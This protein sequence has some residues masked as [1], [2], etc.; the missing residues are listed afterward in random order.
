MKKKT[1]KFNRDLLKN[2]NFRNKSISST[3][4]YLKDSKIENIEYDWNK[5]SLIIKEAVERSISRVQDGIK[6]RK[7][8]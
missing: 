5:T 7:K 4:V 6:T 2:E 8:K 1:V 3:D